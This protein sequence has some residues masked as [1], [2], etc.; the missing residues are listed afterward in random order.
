MKVHF[1]RYDSPYI[2]SGYAL[3]RGRYGVVVRRSRGMREVALSFGYMRTGGDFVG[4]K[5]S[6]T[7]VGRCL[8]SIVLIRFFRSFFV[9]PAGPS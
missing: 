3:G 8:S 2:F 1:C 4:E 9:V 6:R 5:L 7:M